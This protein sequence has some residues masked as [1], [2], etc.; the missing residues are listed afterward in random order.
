MLIATD[1]DHTAFGNGL[2]EDALPGV[3]FHVRMQ[4]TTGEFKPELMLAPCRKQTIDIQTGESI[5]KS[6]AY[7]Y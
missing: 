1:T 7:S 2:I 6:A 5:Q 4:F 3:V